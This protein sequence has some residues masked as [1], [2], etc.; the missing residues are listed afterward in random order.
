MTSAPGESAPAPAVEELVML[1]WTTARAALA[2]R[3]LRLRVLVPPYP[4]LG[5]GVLRCLRVMA[6]GGAHDGALELIAGYD[7]YERR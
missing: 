3:P 6:L 4:A 7:G 1:P 5:V 2:D